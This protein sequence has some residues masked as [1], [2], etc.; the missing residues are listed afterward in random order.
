MKI[1][2]LGGSFDPP[3][4]GHFLIAEQVNE[5]LGLDQVWL[6]PM[7]STKAHDKVFQK[8]LSSVEDR[9][10]MAK[11]LESDKIKVSDFE[12]KHNQ[13]SITII[14]LEKL[15]QLHPE[16]EFYWITGSDKLETFQKYDRWRDIITQHKLIIFPRE[17]VL[18]FFKEK[19]ME[20]LQLRTIPESVI[21]FQNDHLVLTNISSTLIRL[22]VKNN[23]PVHYLVPD[24]VEEYIKYHNLYK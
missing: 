9:I 15:C 14:T 24:G 5:Q 12:I 13:D 20:T 6:M 16:H 23:L 19:V 11:I 4:L 2:I 7:Y 3:H 17:W 10:A 21:V 22:R 18:P 1:G 8:K